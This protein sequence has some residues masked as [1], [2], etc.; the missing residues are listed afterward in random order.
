MSATTV[1]VGSAVTC[2]LL[3]VV[4]ASTMILSLCLLPLTR[5]IPPPSVA[6]E[7][8]LARYDSVARR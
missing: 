6:F 3:R 2:H 5:A 1:S 4:I 8:G 7:D